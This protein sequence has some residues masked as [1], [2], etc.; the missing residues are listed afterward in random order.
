MNIHDAIS[1]MVRRDETDKGTL[2]LGEVM[3]ALRSLPKG[4]L[5]TING[6]KPTSI[7]SYRGYY[8]HLAI[9]TD[10]R[11]GGER[12][13]VIEP[14]RGQY[15][16][17]N[18]DAAEVLI[19]SCGV[20]DDLLNALALCIGATFQGY[21]GGDFTM[22]YDTLMFAAEWGACGQ[23]IVGVSVEDDTVALTVAVD[24]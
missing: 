21:K 14:Y 12:S 9:A 10:E 17:S 3:D 18:A 5:V 20:V 15:S 4:S 23:R 19:G 1:A 8:E 22:G 7:N 6:K 16:Y 2:T 13:E 24:E 11:Q